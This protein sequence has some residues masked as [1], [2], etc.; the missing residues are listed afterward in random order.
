MFRH[1][2]CHILWFYQISQAIS[3]FYNPI[4]SPVPPIQ[5]L[6]RLI[7]SSFSDQDHQIRWW[8][9]HCCCRSHH[10][11][12]FNHLQSSCFI[13]NHHVPSF[14]IMFHHVSSFFIMFHHFSSLFIIKS[15][16]PP[17]LA[18][19]PPFFPGWVPNI[20]ASCCVFWSCRRLSSLI[21]RHC[22][23]SAAWGTRW[24]PQ[25]LVVGI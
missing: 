13:I 20:F 8:N 1:I 21:S 18:V 2:T 22:C 15:V 19:K 10:S 9:P 3:R 12:W 11:W 5:S 4:L 17:F 16:K 23:T 24:N 6:L 14:F 7:K 25:L